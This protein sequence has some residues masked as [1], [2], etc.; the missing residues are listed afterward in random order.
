MD[1]SDGRVLILI[2]VAT[3]V[4]FIGRRYQRT[5]DAWGGRGKAVK[6]AADAKDKIPA[7]KAAAWAA[8]RGMVGAGLVVLILF[9]IVANAIR[10]G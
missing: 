8:I 7:A 6:A 10:Y 9:A 5:V 1:S 3:V 4:F 2:V